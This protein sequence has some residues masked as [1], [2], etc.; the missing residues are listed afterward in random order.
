M[1]KSSFRGIG[2]VLFT[3]LLTLALTACGG[4][5]GG[6]GDGDGDGSVPTIDKQ[7]SEKVVGI[8]ILSQ[9]ISDIGTKTEIESTGTVAQRLKKT[10][11]LNIAGRMLDIAKSKIP[12]FNGSLHITGTDSGQEYCS[13]GGSVSYSMSW[14]GPDYPQYCS[15]IKNLK[16]NFTFQNCKEGTTTMNGSFL[17]TYSGDACSLPSA[18]TLTLSDFSLSDLSE[19]LYFSCSY[20]QLAYTEVT[21]SGIM[22]THMKVKF[23]GD[24]TA[25]YK[26]DDYSVSYDNYYLVLDTDDSVNYEITVGGSLT[27]GCFD[28]WVTLETLEPILVN[29]YQE[30]P[31]GGKIRIIGNGETVVQF[32]SDGSVDIDDTHYNSCQELDSECTT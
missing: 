12:S 28:G 1:K 26:G 7:I 30:C 29:T 3:V 9:G 16:A 11:S 19:E 13:N 18:F 23:N 15:D 20:F 25:S 5:G 10:S 8:T 22:I 4:G 32:N 17:L 27:G 24:A 14:D 6:G 31:I 21:W 2:E